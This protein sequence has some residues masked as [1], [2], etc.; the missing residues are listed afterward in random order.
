MNYDVRET[1]DP[2]SRPITASPPTPTH[3]EVHG[4]DYIPSQERHGRPFELFW[5]W[6]GSNVNYL[7]FVFGG[8]LIL[9]GL[10][11]W[12]AIAVTILGRGGRS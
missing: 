2:A 1:A 7:S 10:T 11:V 6:M 5:V 4:I 3:V 12:E 8:L 9:I